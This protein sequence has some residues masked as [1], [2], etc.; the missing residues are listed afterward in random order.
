ATFAGKSPW[1]SDGWR[2]AL[3]LFLDLRD[4]GVIAN[5]ALPTGGDDNTTGEKEFFNVQDL[6]T[7]FDGSFAIGVAK[8]TA[9]D[10]TTFTSISVP[11]AANGKLEP[12]S[13]GG[14]GKGGVI[15]PKGKN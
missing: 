14:P 12:R 5:N 2:N 6:A 15:N 9:P 1:K 10:F 4:A 8:T 3:Q 13:P 7:Y 11:K